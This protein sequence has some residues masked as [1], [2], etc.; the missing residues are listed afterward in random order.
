MFQRAPHCNRKP[1]VLG[2]ARKTGAVD[3][4]ADHEELAAVGHFDELR[5]DAARCAERG[6]HVEPRAGP[7]VFGKVKAGGVEAFGDVAA[8]VDAQEE[9]RHPLRAFALQGGGA[10]AGLLEADAKARGEVVEV[11]LR[12]PRFGQKGGVGHQD[13]GGEVVGQFDAQPR[14]TARFGQ[15]GPLDQRIEQW[16]LFQ[17]PGHVDQLERAV[18]VVER[19]GQQDLAPRLVVLTQGSGQVFNP[20]KPHA[21]TVAVAQAGLQG[22][23][24]FIRLD[25]PIP[26]RPGGLFKLAKVVAVAAEDVVDRRLGRA[27]QQ[28]GVSLGKGQKLV[29]GR[30]IDPVQGEKARHQRRGMYQGRAQLCQ[31]GAVV[32]KERALDHRAQISELGRAVLFGQLPPVDAVRLEQAQQDS[33]RDRSFIV[34]QKVDVRRGNP[35]RACHGGLGF[36]PLGAK[37][38]Q[39]GADKGFLHTAAHNP[40]FVVFTIL[41]I[42]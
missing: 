4:A 26:E 8:F 17:K 1:V 10:V 16:P 38:S 39:M 9:E 25:R 24:D 5:H 11:V 21:D 30:L 12:G 34:F 28:G 42:I 37:T 18:G 13:R 36:A 23:V 2:V 15:P 29:G 7:A 14:H 31:V 40:S 41:Q 19:L 3:G 33:H 27:G 35:E 32:G 6:V 22:G 20:A